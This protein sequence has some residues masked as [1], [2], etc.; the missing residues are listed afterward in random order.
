MDNPLSAASL[1]DISDKSSMDTNART[2]KTTF[3]LDVT[4][5]INHYFHRMF[6]HSIDQKIQ[7]QYQS[8]A[9][10]NVYE[11][12]Q[13]LDEKEA[14][15]LN[16]L[17]DSASKDKIIKA[18]LKTIN[19]LL[20][21]SLIQEAKSVFNNKEETNSLRALEYLDDLYQEFRRTV[22]FLSIRDRNPE[23][24]IAYSFFSYFS[25]SR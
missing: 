21:G 3:R 6:N 15:F 25:I 2:K 14:A 20:S 1:E 12:I 5:A 24:H 17:K 18:E 22:T 23:D 13:P 8:R 7:T 19:E 11:H 4:K 9:I 10:R 16:I